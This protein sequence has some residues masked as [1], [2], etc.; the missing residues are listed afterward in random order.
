M[1]KNAKNGAKKEG[2]Q[3]I[4]GLRVPSS[5]RGEALPTGEL[6]KDYVKKIQHA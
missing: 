4:D 1:Q 2:K 3:N 5:R 6:V